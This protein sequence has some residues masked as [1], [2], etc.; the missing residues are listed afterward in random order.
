[1]K[2]AVIDGQGGGVGKALVA[3][4]KQS[5]GSAVQVIALGTN[6]QAT[7]AMLKAGADDGATGENAIIHMSGR[8]DRIM[9]P[10]GII[11]ANAML[12]ELTPAAARAVGESPSPKL[13]IPIRKCGI[14][15]AGNEYKPIQTLVEEAV[16][17]LADDL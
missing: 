4:L 13:L 2:I 9:G 5:Y 11:M 6:A 1:M 14:H 8:V 10:I 17:S 3:R 15:I 12:G 16:A 7:S